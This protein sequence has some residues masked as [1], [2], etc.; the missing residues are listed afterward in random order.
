MKHLQRVAVAIAAA[1]VCQ[2]RVV[3]DFEVVHRNFP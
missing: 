1:D 3:E 2:L